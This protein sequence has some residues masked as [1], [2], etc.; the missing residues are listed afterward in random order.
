VLDTLRRLTEVTMPHHEGR[1]PIL[2]LSS[3]LD[4]GGTELKL[5]ELARRLP[6]DLS[7]RVCST[8][9]RVALR[10]D[11]ERAGA[12][13]TV[14]P[15]ARPWLE[16]SRVLGIARAA[17]RDA[18]RVVNSFDLKGLIIALTV[19]MIA[20]SRV[21]LIHH[22]VNLQFGLSRLHR[23]ALWSLLQRVD[24]VVCDAA[25]IAEELVGDRPMHPEVVVIPNGVDASAFAPPDPARRAHARRALGI[26]DDELLLGTIANFRPTKNY[27]LL[28][29]AFALLFGEHPSLRLV[30]VGQGPQLE[31]V[32]ARA[33]ALGIERAVTFTGVVDDVRPLLAAMDVFVLASRRDAFSN[34]VLQALATGV[35]CICSR[36]GDHRRLM[37]EIGALLFDSTSVD[38]CADA[39]RRMVE[40][41]GL[42]H[43]VA[44]EGRA[45]VEAHYSTEVMVGRYAAL[46]RAQASATRSGG[47]RAA[48]S[49]PPASS[50]STPAEPGTSTARTGDG[51]A[52]RRSPPAAR[53]RDGESSSAGR[54]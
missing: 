50:C 20:G 11:L 1:S 5:L 2:F 27:P 36:T 39:L 51:P 21:R 53:R 22:L 8:S 48:R 46:F 12:V 32:R 18:V 29:D 3:G 34:A 30:C 24:V 4:R 40:D 42:R 38:D 14:V 54:P 45:L 49:T 26:G 13:V 41:E 17:R 7:V 28:L 23:A 16:P 6:A 47:R 25:S 19:R 52:A 35:P 9:E 15:V 31:E 43:R 44:V 37:R 10:G 33:G